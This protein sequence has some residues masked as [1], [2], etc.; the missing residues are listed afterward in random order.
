MTQ[1]CG[2]RA[3]ALSDPTQLAAK[4]FAAGRELLRREADGTKFR[5]IG[6]AASPFLGAARGDPGDLLDEGG[7]ACGGG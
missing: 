1:G 6:I 5:L 2:P 7:I 3:R 4:I